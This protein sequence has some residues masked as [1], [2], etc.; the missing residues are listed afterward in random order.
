MIVSS[1]SKYRNLSYTF[2]SDKIDFKLVIIHITGRQVGAVR[3][4]KHGKLIIFKVITRFMNI[5][6]NHYMNVIITIP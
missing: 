1:V 4:Y 5:M 6:T 3:Q 2:C